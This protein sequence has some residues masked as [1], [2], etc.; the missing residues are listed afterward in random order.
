MT[1]CCTCWTCFRC[2]VGCPAETP[3]WPLASH[4]QSHPVYLCSVSLKMGLSPG[5]ACSC[6]CRSR[7]DC[8]CSL[9]ITSAHLRPLV[10]RGWS[11]TWAPPPLWVSTGSPPD[12]AQ[13]PGT[14]RHHTWV[15]CQS[16]SWEAALQKRTWDPAEHHD[17]CVSKQKA[18]G[19]TYQ[20]V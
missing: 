1:R 8:L 17:G 7:L 14:P 3:S 15:S 6:P 11:T 5:S 16:L 2:S 9:K 10:S 13:A 19:P 20:C 18:L 4:S 12:S